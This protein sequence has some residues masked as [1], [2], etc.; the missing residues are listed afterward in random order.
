MEAVFG[1]ERL[2]LHQ[3]VSTEIQLAP[4]DL[5]STGS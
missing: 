5:A 4:E 3:V 1:F 2:A